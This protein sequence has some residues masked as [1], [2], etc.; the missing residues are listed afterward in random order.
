MCWR[1]LVTGTTLLLA[2]ANSAF[3]PGFS[4]LTRA[5]AERESQREPRRVVLLYDERTDLPGLAML[6][7]SLNRNLTSDPAREV[8]VYRETLDL[9]RFS[10]P[11]Y[12]PEVAAYLKSKYS[13]KRIDAVVAVIG[14][15]L[16]FLLNEGKSVFPGVPVVFCGIDRREFE[17]RVLPAHVT[18]VLLKREFSPTLRL[19]LDLHPGTTR[20]VLVAGN[21]EFDSRLVAQ[22]RQEF[23]EFE[24]RVAFTYLTS[25]ALPEVLTEVSHLPPHTLVLYTTMFRD[26][27]GNTFIP[28]DVAE[29]VSAAANA[30]VY[31]FLDQF[32]GRGIVG[33]RVY[34]TETHGQ[35]AA[36]LVRQILDGRNPSDLPIVEAANSNLLF[37]WQQMQ[38]WGV[39]EAR[40]P[41]GSAIRFRESSIWQRYRSV[42]IVTGVVV[43][44]QMVL[45][46]ALLLETSVR[47]RAQIALRDNEAALK[48]RT[49]Q[50]RDL[51]GQLITAQEAER[52]RIAR[53]LHDDIGQRIAAF[54]ISIT[55]IKRQPLVQSTEG[56]RNELASLQ[57][58]TI[59]LSES[60]RH[61][62]HDLHP[63]TLQ[64]AGIAAVLRSHCEE[65][66]KQNG[67]EVVFNADLEAD[68]IEPPVAL[69]LFRVTQEALQ[70]IARHAAARHVQVSLTRS[71]TNVELSIADDGS[72]FDT[73]RA[74]LG[75]GGLGLQSIRE[76]VRMAHG[77]LVIDSAPGRGTTVWVS[78]AAT[79]PEG[80]ALSKVVW[81]KTGNTTE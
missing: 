72:G 66:A 19:A 21:S 58:R 68:A 32:I 45:I 20:V 57:N 64:H 38:R 60:V 7:A 2:V 3:S 29:R 59:D 77:R 40:L 74:H 52:A 67:S 10:A 55:S 14:P 9:S 39:D 44:L 1:E 63:A 62:S 61:L 65:F 50:V 78:V 75:G 12:L 56:L 13:V 8:E 36:E 33:G 51:A 28:H 26:A 76:R 34:S 24:G 25:S 49:D 54:A 79:D 15:S 37:D 11:R 73:E 35:Q 18:G 43:V 42:I 27:A 71:E 70:N 22:A 47:R 4:G 81:R 31:G 48:A 5:A 23:R 16:D 69:C 41:V 30:P 17:R 53:E 6:D 46:V 80:R